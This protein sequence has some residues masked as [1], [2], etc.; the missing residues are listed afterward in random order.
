MSSRAGP[1]AIDPASMSTI[2]YT[3]GTTGVP[4]GVVLTHDNLVAGVCSAIRAMGV[5]ASDEQYL[6]LP[7]AHVLGRELEWCGIEA[8]F[9]TA[10]SRGT[11]LIK[12]DL[13]VIRPTFMAGVP[14]I[15]EK[16]YAGVTAA[17]AQGTGSSASSPAGRSRRAAARAAALGEASR[18]PAPGWPTSWCCRS[19]A[20]G[21]GSIAAASWSRAARRWRAEIGEFFH[22]TGLLIL[23][24]YGLTETM[25][26]AHLNVHGPSSASAPSVRRWTSSRRRSPTTARS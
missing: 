16:F 17:L 6:F 3:S 24:G 14:R 9:P 21:W 13:A 12:E 19:C 5:V 8:G 20:R 25:A 4:K 1:T 7:L 26:A 2:I 11:A 22:S 23:E 10:F 15:F 18:R